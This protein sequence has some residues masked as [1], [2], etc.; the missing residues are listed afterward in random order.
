MAQKR[1]RRY[2]VDFEH[3]EN[4]MLVEANLGWQLYSRDR[5]KMSAERRQ[6]ITAMMRRFVAEMRPDLEMHKE[7]VRAAQREFKD[8]G[9]PVLMDGNAVHPPN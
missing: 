9:S 7:A 1:E 5:H 3:F 4:A 6:K 8:T 2:A